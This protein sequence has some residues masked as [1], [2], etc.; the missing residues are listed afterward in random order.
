MNRRNYMRHQLILIILIIGILDSSNYLY[1]VSASDVG[2]PDAYLYVA[3]LN[4]IILD[5]VI[6]DDEYPDTIRINDIQG[7]YVNDLSWGHNNTH[8][9]IGMA[10]E[11]TG[12]VSIGLGE[13]GVTMFGADIIMGSV[14]GN[15]V[16][17]KDMHSTGQA[18]PIE[19]QDSYIQPNNVAGIEADGQTLIEL[20]IPLQSDDIVGNDHN[21]FVNN[22]YGFYTAYHETDDNFNSTHTAHSG[23]LTV[24][25]VDNPPEAIEIQLTL[26]ATVNQDSDTILLSSKTVGIIDNKPVPWIEISF[27]RRTLYGYLLY[28]TSISDENGIATTEIVVDF[29]GNVTLTAMYTGSEN[30]K[31]AEIT[32]WVIIDYLVQT[33][34]EFN[35]LRDTFNDKYLIRNFLL[36]LLYVILIILLISYVSVVLDL[37]LLYRSRYKEISLAEESE[38]Q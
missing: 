33:E 4:E 6:E 27:Y 19:D 8:L 12:W 7:N 16:I 21:W 3:D 25:V 36:I 2:A 35:D 31:R 22:T 20:I 15:Q 38:K 11:G 32:T 10:F 13:I 29:R 26:N 17:I 5:G 30:Y 14:S 1:T 37:F 18:I 28:N 23:H 34:E 24:K 9:A